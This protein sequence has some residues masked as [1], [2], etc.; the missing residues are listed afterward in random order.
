MLV[1]IGLAAL[2]GFVASRLDGDSSSQPDPTWTPTPD[3]DTSWVVTMADI[4]PAAGDA[5]EIAIGVDGAFTGLSFVAD[6]TAFVVGYGVDHEPNA[7]AGID[8]TDGTLLWT[9]EMP[10]ALCGDQAFDGALAC[11]SHEDGEWLYH[12][13][14]IVTGE[15]LVMT[16][17][18]VRGALTVHAGPEALVVV[19]PA[20][21]APHADLT[22][23]GLDGELL[24]KVDLATIEGAEYLFDDLI[25]SDFGNAGAADATMERPRWRDLDGGLMMLWVTPGVALIDPAAGTVLAHECLRATPAHDHYF[26]QDDAGINRRDLTG[27]V[28]WSLPDL[29][30]AYVADTSD[31]RPVAVSEVFEVIPVDWE[32]G[33]VTGPAIHRFDPQPG[34]FTGSI[35]G[36]SAAGDA[37]TQYLEQDGEV[38]VRLTDDVDDVQW[39]FTGGD[40]VSYIDEALTVGDVT[41]VDAYTLIGLDAATGE[42]LWQ[43]ENPYGIYT[44]RFESSLVAI[45][46]DEIARLELP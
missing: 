41:V 35:M 34:G 3:I 31:A 28:V 23:I 5:V 39:V 17:A 4:D 44:S 32:T 25:A 24:W 9:R 13:V 42:E 33:E 14:D 21:P 40:D 38:L 16:E 45:G 26:C 10:S 27:E 46:F 20:S 18:P 29:D 2:S 12:L 30:L 15:D 22:A 19:G 1:V 43:R 8:P 11:L 6:P 36:P 7:L 37:Q